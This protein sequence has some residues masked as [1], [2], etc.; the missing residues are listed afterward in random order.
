V[1]QIVD[2]SRP[3]TFTVSPKS[4]GYRVGGLALAIVGPTLIAGWFL[5]AHSLEA[6]VK[7]TPLRYGLAPTLFPRE[8]AA[9]DH[10]PGFVYTGRF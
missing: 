5:F 10:V 6:E 1:S 8:S 3:V 2:V 9:S 4:E 7:E